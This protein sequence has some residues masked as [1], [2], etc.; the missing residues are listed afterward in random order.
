[1]NRAGR[2]AFI[3]FHAAF[4]SPVWA[5][6]SNGG[7]FIL[8]SSLVSGSQQIATGGDFSVTGSAGEPFSHVTGDN[9]VVRAPLVRL[10]DGFLQPLWV[11]PASRNVLSLNNGGTVII[12]PSGAMAEAYQADIELEPLSQPIVI[13]PSVLSQANQ[14][15]GM[16]LP[17][18]IIE[19]RLL[20]ISGGLLPTVNMNQIDFQVDYPGGAVGIYRFE[21][22]NSSWEKVSGP[23]TLR[24]G[25]IAH[26]TDRDAGIFALFS[27]SASAGLTEPYVFPVPWR[28]NGGNPLLY[29]T[30]LDGV[31]FANVSS[32]REVRIYSITGD[33]VRTIPVS[34]GSLQA[35][36]DGRTDGGADAVSGVYIWTVEMD[37]SRRKGKL[38]VIR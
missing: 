25:I 31:T 26:F 10:F 5:L 9:R 12:I 35:W 4:S 19:M 17:I 32:A 15:L 8:D 24:S 23:T 14:Q 27:L 22:T 21:D 18:S 7:N 28:P 16:D 29:G 20:G 34:A 13:S 33:L 36:W 30:R 6:V 2:L 1:M 3:L 37:G 11:D 38:M